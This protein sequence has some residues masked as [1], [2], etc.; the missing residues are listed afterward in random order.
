M[1]IKITVPPGKI[2]AF[3][4]WDLQS[5][6]KRYTV[7]ATFARFYKE[8]AESFACR[9]RRLDDPLTPQRH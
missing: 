8:I 7:E 3:C 1:L 5:G 2:K 4:N 9:G 6:C